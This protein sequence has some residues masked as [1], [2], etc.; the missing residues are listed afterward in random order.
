MKVLSNVSRAP[1][2][3]AI[4]VALVS[5]SCSALKGSVMTA[6]MCF[7]RGDF[8][9]LFSDVRWVNEFLGTIGFCAMAPHAE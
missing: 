8:I 3:V 4:A 9:G 2:R 5:A 6:A 7:Q 1:Q